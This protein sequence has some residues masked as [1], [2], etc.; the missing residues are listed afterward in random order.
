MVSQHRQIGLSF[1]NLLDQMDYLLIIFPGGAKVEQGVERPFLTVDVGGIVLLQRRNETLHFHFL[2]G[3]ECLV[4]FEGNFH[5]RRL[6]GFV[7]L[8]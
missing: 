1:A 4:D 5:S 2:G 7:A 8:R 6:M 3:C